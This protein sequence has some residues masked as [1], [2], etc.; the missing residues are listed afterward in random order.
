MKKPSLSLSAL[1][2]GP[3]IRPVRDWLVMLTIF[4][5]FLLIS[6]AW[7]LWL[8]SQVTSGNKIGTQSSQP[9]VE[10]KLDQVKTLFDSRAAEQT[11]YIQEYKFVDPSL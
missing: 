1:K 7:N 3:R 4:A 10:I 11:R 8:F 9:A 2:Y 6:L 5:L